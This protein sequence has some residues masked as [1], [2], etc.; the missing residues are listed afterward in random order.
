LLLARIDD[1]HGG[2]GPG[3]PPARDGNRLKGMAGFFQFHFAFRNFR[4]REIFGSMAGDFLPSNAIDLRFFSFDSEPGS[5]TGASIDRED[6][7]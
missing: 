2:S 7:R 5:K 1:G 3:S 6:I 4:F